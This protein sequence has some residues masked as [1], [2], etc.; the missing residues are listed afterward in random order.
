[1]IT[2]LLIALF[3]GGATMLGGVFGYFMKRN[4][5]AVDGAVFSFAAGVMLAASFAELIL[6]VTN[7]SPP[8]RLALGLAGI[9][10]GGALLH[11][12]QKPLDRFAASRIRLH[13][14]FAATDQKKMTEALLFVAAITIHNLPEGLAAGIGAGTDDFRKTLTV[15]AGV[16]L[17]NIPEG[18]IV[19][20]PLIAAGF[21]RK[22]ALAVSILTGVI[23]IAGTFLGY[24]ATAAAGSIL[25]FF[26]CLA[27]GCMLYII[28]TD[29]IG[30][31][32]RLAGKT[33]SGYAFLFGCCGMLLMDRFFS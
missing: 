21:S 30:D 16:A 32:N 22:R 17:Q 2:V 27:G 25:P 6:P 7:G 23:E 10:A 15:A 13:P 26:L 29:V 1:M 8:L 9:L 12:L 28:C 18:M 19:L 24:F 20:T 5:P 3:V 31:A 4:A 14:A 11:L 33:V